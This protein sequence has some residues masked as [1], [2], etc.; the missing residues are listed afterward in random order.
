MSGP[1]NDYDSLSTS[2]LLSSLELS[3]TNVCE[4]QIRARLETA[5]YFYDCVAATL[6]LVAASVVASDRYLIVA[7]P[8]RPTLPTPRWASSQHLHLPPVAAQLH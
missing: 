4:P 7:I 6:L 2:L 3:A 5:A 1:S 8:S